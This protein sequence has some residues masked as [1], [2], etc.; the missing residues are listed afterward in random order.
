M[1]SLCENALFICLLGVV[2][3]AQPRAAQANW[4]TEI[5]VRNWPAPL[6]WQQSPVEAEATGKTEHVS[7]QVT[8]SSPSTPMIF[9]GM[10]PCRVVDTR[11]S[12]TINPALCNDPNFGPPSMVNG[13]TRNFPFQSS[14]TCSIPSSAAAYSLNV[15]VVPQSI[16]EFVGAVIMWPEG[17]SQPTAVTLDDITGDI[18]NNAAIMP[19]GTPNGGLSVFVNAT[20]D[21]VIDINGYY[22]PLNGFDISPGSVTALG[23][24]ALSSGNSTGANN[25]A[26]GNNTLAANTSGADN[27]AVGAGTLSK[28]TTGIND[29]ALGA[30]ALQH[31]IDGGGNTA[32]G[33]N[34]LSQNT[35]GSSNTG[36]GENTLKTNTTA[37]NS[38]AVGKNALENATGANNI[39]L[40]LSAGVNISAGSN[41]IDIGNAGASTDG[42]SANSGVIRIGTAN[43]QTSFFTAGINNSTVSGAAVLV[44]GTTGQLGVQSSSARY[45]EDIHDMADASS[46]LFDLRPVTFRYKKPAN[47][48]SKPIDYGLIAEEV[49]KVYPDLVVRNAKGEVETVQYQKL[50]PMLLNELQK[51]RATVRAQDEEL[52][53]QSKR[54]DSLEDQVSKLRELIE[55]LMSNKPDR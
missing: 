4:K 11:S 36:I 52:Q 33:V 24:G 27:T 19:A 23:N 25:T 51:G 43:S 29:S 54:I 45:K 53:Q 35:D 28:N 20:T 48:G 39:A 22:V 49:D 14:S 1:S 50:T 9:V 8:L 10:T 13:A 12:C 55:L 44:D 37:N 32:V 6:Y 16:G 30:L 38:T 34:A 18:R 5:P 47:D 46:R 2:A 42:I 41:N 26:I 31:N 3:S 21:L 40:G 15:T 7:A 17:Q